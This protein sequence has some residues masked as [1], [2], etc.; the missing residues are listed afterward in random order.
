MKKI[1]LIPNTFV[2]VVVLFSIATLNGFAKQQRKA[3]A[4]SDQE[5]P[6]AI[7]A[8]AKKLSENR[9]WHVDARIQG[10][11]QANISGIVA[12]NDF[13]L[14]IETV[15]GTKRQ[16]ILGEKSWISEDGGKTWKDADAKD[17]RFYYLVHTP[18]RFVPDQPIPPHEKIA[19]AKGETEPLLHVRFKSP[20]KIHYEGDR[21]NWWIALENGKPTVIRH[22]HGPGVWEGASDY[23]TTDAFYTEINDQPPVVAPPGNPHAVAAE[24]GPERLLMTAMKKMDEGVW[25]VNGTATFTKTIK[26]HGLLSGRDFDITMEPENGAAIRRLIVI[27]DKAWASSDAGKTFHPGTPNDRLVYNLTHTPILSGRLEPAFE[28]LDSEQHDG[29]TWLHIRLKVNEKADQTNLPQYWLVLDGQ[30]QAQYIARASTPMVNPGDNNVINCK[31]DYAPA[32]QKIAPPALGAPVDDKAHGF[33]EIEQH[34]FDWAGKVVKI[35][36]DP[37]LLQSEELPD[38]NYRGFLKDTAT[39]NHYGVVEFPYDSLVKLGFLKKIVKGTHAWEQL[40]QMGAAGRTE[41]APVSFYVEVIPIG[42]RPAA[43][44]VVVGAK[45]VREADGTATYSW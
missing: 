15:E 21:P 5:K 18:I 40:K 22:Y 32:K 35:E 20:E 33:N 43:R 4:T 13:D 6:E 19:P 44:T 7:L 11:K 28:K 25:E 23:V 14:T 1:A 45:L 34:K 39:P 10:E 16:I 31:F 42:E 9:A 38:D 2:L 12:G 36:V 8:A 24:S 30:G 3:A 37:K 17:R 27:K 41:G 29:A 26:L